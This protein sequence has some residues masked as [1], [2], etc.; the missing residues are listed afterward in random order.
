MF[1]LG[2]FRI[3]ILSLFYN[4]KWTRELNTTGSWRKQSSRWNRWVSTMMVVG[5]DS[6]LSPRNS[7]SVV[8]LTLFAHRNPKSWRHWESGVI[9]GIWRH[10][11]LTSKLGSDVMGIGRRWD[12]TS[13][14]FDVIWTRVSLRHWNRWNRGLIF[15]TLELCTIP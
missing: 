15:V 6:F 2:P 12:L 7:I 14:G 1:L 11:D 10:G 13:L 5:W 8:L 4:R 3:V 9:K